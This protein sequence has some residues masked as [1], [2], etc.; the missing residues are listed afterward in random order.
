MKMADAL[1]PCRAAS[2]ETGRAS[3]DLAN[4]TQYLVKLSQYLVEVFCPR[5]ESADI[6]NMLVK[7][8]GGWSKC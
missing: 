6:A 2:T 1:N 8:A 3:P 5:A 7:L 4:L